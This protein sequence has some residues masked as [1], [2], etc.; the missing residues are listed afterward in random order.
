MIFG[1][2]PTRIGEIRVARAA[3]LGRARIDVREYF[4]DSTGELRPTRKGINI[5]VPELPRLMAAVAAA[6]RDAIAAGLL[7]PEDY[8]NAGLPIPKQLG[9]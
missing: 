8:E 2:V 9:A 7:L 4:T 6:E 3:F 5:A 1:T